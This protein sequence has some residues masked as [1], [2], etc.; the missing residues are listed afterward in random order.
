MNLH[1][2]S[3]AGETGVDE[4]APETEEATQAASFKIF[5]HRRLPVTES[6]SIMIRIAAQHG[7]ECRQDEREHKDNLEAC[8]DE[9]DL[10][11]PA[12]SNNIEDERETDEG[13]EIPS[14]VGLETIR[15]VYD[16]RTR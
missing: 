7:D 16:V 11:V 14:R 1:I 5:L 12:H 4:N 10:T 15:S 8:R 9:L 2:W 3:S 6:V 13:Q